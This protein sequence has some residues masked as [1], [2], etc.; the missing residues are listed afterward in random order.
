MHPFVSWLRKN[1]PP[2]CDYRFWL[3]Q[4]L[5]VISCVQVTSL[6]SS[7]ESVVALSRTLETSWVLK[8][9]VLFFLVAALSSGIIFGLR[10]SISTIFVTL[11][12][13]TPKLLSWSALS[14]D[15]VILARVTVISGLS[16]G[17]AYLVS[18][19]RNAR[20]NLQVLNEKMKEIIREKDRF[21]KLASEAQENERR[22]ISRDLHD[23]SLQLL[24]AVLHQLDGAIKAEDGEKAKTQM[25]R[26]KATITQTTDA[27]RRYCEALRP[28]LL[29]TLG[30]VAS[31]EWIAEELEKTSGIKVDFES[32]G[33]SH[34]IRDDDRIHVFRVMQEAFHNIEK[35]SKATAVR[36]RW[37]Y[38]EE[39]L[40]ISVTDN[41]IGM[42]NFGSSPARSLGIQG[43]YERMELVGGKLKI[44]SQPGFG[45]KVSLQI[46]FES[47]IL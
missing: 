28:Q 20:L 17:V 33:E 13:L 11:F 7:G 10:G 22:R 40:E 15:R 47:I 38:S 34:P 23:D 14:Y 30:L 16:I 8:S 4:L 24:A 39:D 27:I 35:H 44:E 12:F 42:W 46:P 32:E 45:T 31:V 26:A 36:V 3:I 29:D 9:F 19:E 21:F 2:Y 18:R 41:G 5:N 25:V 43:M 1:S 6:P 37:K